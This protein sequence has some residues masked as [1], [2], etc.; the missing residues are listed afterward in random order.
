MRLGMALVLKGFHSF[1]LHT[2]T[3]IR[4]R[5]EP[6]LPLP[7]QPQ[8]VLI[9]L[10]LWYNAVIAFFTKV[11]DPYYQTRTG[12][13][14]VLLH[15]GSDPQTLRWIDA[16]P[17]LSIF[18]C[19]NSSLWHCCFVDR[20][21][22]QPVNSWVLVWWWWWFDCSFACLIAPIVTTT[23]VPSSLAPVKPANSDSPGKAVKTERER[24]T[25]ADS[26]LG[27]RA[28][29]VCD[30][31]CGLFLSLRSSVKSVFIY[32]PLRNELLT[33]SRCA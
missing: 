25:V 23:T 21:G 7:S 17:C 14:Q 12:S 1:Y 9:N 8:L 27:E 16:V 19:N 32:L 2:H 24:D 31:L 28:S 13:G 11:W 30:V 6:Y 26:L 20:K 33:C 4:Y 5:N 15:S 22:I 18:F 29:I 3:F 10:I